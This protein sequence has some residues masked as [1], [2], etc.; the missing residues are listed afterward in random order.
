MDEG[1][2]DA[3]EFARELTEIAARGQA[4]RD[5][6]RQAENERLDASE[7]LH[8]DVLLLHSGLRDAISPVHVAQGTVNR[9]PYLVFCWT[10][11]TPQRAAFI[12]IDDR[13]GILSW[14][15]AY[16]TNPRNTEPGVNW[17]RIDTARVTIDDIKALIRTLGAES[18]WKDGAIPVGPAELHDLA[19]GGD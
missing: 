10:P 8:R 6:V 17:T 5:A 13:T 1:S 2:N 4:E 3:A 7:R 14:Q 12:S 19:P 18:E 9:K 15:L 16:A 11:T